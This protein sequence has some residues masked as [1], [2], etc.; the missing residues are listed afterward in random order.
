M[1]I[2]EQHPTT[3]G[4]PSVPDTALLS[5]LMLDLTLPMTVA[6]YAAKVISQRWGAECP[7]AVLADLNYDFYAHP[8][9]GDVHL[10]KVRVSKSLVQALLDNDQTVGAGRFG[11][12]AFGLYT[13]PVVGPQMRIVEIDESI[14]PG[15]GF[16]DYEGIYRRTSP[17]VYGPDT[18]LAL[19]PAAFKAWVWALEF[20][21][22]YATYVAAAWPDDQTLLADAAY[23]QRTA[24]KLAFVMAAYLQHQEHSLSDAGL[25][26]ALRVAGLDGQQA[27]AQLTPAQLQASTRVPPSVEAARLM[28][29]RYTAEDIWRFRD[30]STG[31]LLLYIPGNASPFHEFADH[32]A[33]CEGLVDMARD[34]VRKQALA[35]HF[36]EDDRQDGTFHAGVLTALDGM[37][38]YP[39]QYHLRKHHGFFNNDGYWLPQAYIGAEVAPSSVDPF[40]QWVQ[41]MKRA[42]QASVDSIR[43]DAQVNRDNLSAVVEPL[44]QWINRFAPLALFVPGG[45]GVLALAGLID[46]GYGLDRAVHGSTTDERWAGVGRTVFGVL[47]ALPMIKAGAVLKNEG[48]AVAGEMPLAADRAVTEVVAPRISPLRELVPEAGAFSDNVLSDIERVCGLD[49]DMLALI[50]AGQRPPPI[51]TDT[52]SRFRIDQA[53]QQVTDLSARI[54][55]FDRR[56]AAL[57][58]SGHEWVRLF[59]S[60]YPGLPKSAIEQMLDRS[61][62][63]VAAPHT[64]ADAKRV[65]HELSAKAQQYE[66]H[67]R[68]TRAY[69]GLHLGSVTNADS[70]V[71]ALHSLERLAGWPAGVR[72]EI[73]E[74]SAAGKVLD[75]I[76]QLGA[77]YTRQVI[78]LGTRY[79]GL[80]AGQTLD[81]HQALLNALSSE[82]R[83]A[84]G[85]RTDEALE[86][87]RASIRATPLARA[88]LETGLQRMDAGL[89]FDSFG[90]RGGGF[91]TTAQAEG[92]S[93]S[94]VKLQAHEIY[95]AMTDAELEALLNRWGASAQTQLILL[96]QQMRQLRVDLS[97]WIEQVEDDVV[98]MDVD[99]LRAGDPQA[100]G[101]NA[102]QIAQQNDARIADA[103]NFERQSR[104]EL[105]NELAGLWQ[106][107]GDP[108]RRV[109]SEGQMIGF[110]LE[111]DFEHFH[112]LPA[113]NVSLSEVVELTMSNFSLT[114][115][116]SLSP[117]LRAFPRLRVLDLAA[118]DLH[119]P[120]AVLPWVSPLPPAISEL[121]ELTH[122]NLSQ[123]G[124]MLTEQTAGA[125]SGLSR[126]TSLDLS[127]NPLVRPPL[128]VHLPA[129]RRLN[130]RATGIR[131]CP[132][133]VLDHPYLQLLDLRDNRIDRIP[134]SV[135]LQSVPG[136]RLLLTGNPINDEDSLR[137]IIRHREETGINVWMGLPTVD[138]D[139]PDAWLA[140]LAPERATVHRL[141][142]QHL[143]AMHGSERFFGTLDI[144]RRTADF[145]VNY[146]ALQQ[147]IWRLIDT[148]E[149]SPLLCQQMFQDVE[150]AAVDGDNPFASFEQLEAR[151]ARFQEGSAV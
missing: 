72:I 92:L 3:A 81:F 131:N 112:N 5:A 44:A 39:R 16:R 94:I 36:A 121:K 143:V 129:L 17:Q 83:V 41:V 102:R 22:Q 2:Y 52:L 86:D 80:E 133:G 105:A 43:D 78:K 139:Q 144:I 38:T 12:T 97:G 15:G 82:Q 119:Q 124:L 54:Q 26:L 25:E 47:C 13:P 30:R 55:Q 40:A 120:G 21:D 107:R 10:G 48:R 74:A 135:R 7:E 24:V 110:R 31:R 145:R 91:P 142:W 89:S 117:F 114:E 64:L 56:Y 28:I 103:L 29:Y 109:Y 14:N 148:V 146:L 57:Q 137:W 70:D 32:L 136:S 99:L 63:D 50:K 127:G 49:A 118:T 23:P 61:G 132:V 147:R 108:T 140:G 45:E 6:Q 138:F 11:E 75:S 95:P 67:V 116:E 34:D 90:L 1:N 35:L 19:Q 8:A 66:S 58:Q 88:E 111:M 18:Q 9:Q 62:I 33:L 87:L 101:L 60:Q 59:Q 69:E 126:L 151:V 141:H 77:S 134:L 51:L 150:W 106:L 42:A 128:V 93:R 53:L 85:L 149:A 71:L 73:R 79:Q 123:T 96:N 27:W 68:M 65:L 37:L 130:L 113:L 98:N 84:L 20:K 104:R 76:G 125:L 122:L 46:A 4:S 115:P 100:A